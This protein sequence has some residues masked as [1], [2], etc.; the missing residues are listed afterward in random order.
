MVP[1]ANGPLIVI[2]VGEM[3]AACDDPSSAVRWSDLSGIT[4]DGELVRNVAVST[5]YQAVHE[6][7][8]SNTS[9]DPDGRGGIVQRTA[10]ARTT[11][12]DTR[13]ALSP[14]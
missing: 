7:G 2:C 5:R 1:E 10:V 4:A 9:S 13:L 14:G 6:G 11:P 12:P 3:T 8:C